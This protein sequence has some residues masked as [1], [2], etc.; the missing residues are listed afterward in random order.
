ML[1]HPLPLG[2]KNITLNSYQIFQKVPTMGGGIPLPTPSPL[3]SNIL[4]NNIKT[5]PPPLVLQLLY[6]FRIEFML[7]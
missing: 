5:V 2:S 7:I 6:I 3:L 4:I 1:I